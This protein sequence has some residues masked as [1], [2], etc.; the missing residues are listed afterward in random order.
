MRMEQ[1]H[2]TRARRLAALALRTLGACVVITALAGPAQAEMM[3]YEFTGVVDWVGAIGSGWVLD[4]SVT[5]GT[6]FSGRFTFDSDAPDLDPATDESRYSNPG[7]SL[8]VDVG[9]YSWSSGDGAT[10]GSVVVGG[11]WFGAVGFP[12]GSSLWA[13]HFICGLTVPE[14]SG[15]ALPVEPFPLLNSSFSAKIQDVPFSGESQF[16]GHLTQ[17]NIVPE[18][19]AVLLIAVGL[20]LLQHRPAFRRVG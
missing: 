8:S 16:G 13:N 12:A 10:E 19:A 14:L 11:F 6:P 20:A 17:F 1:L 9:S 3:A 7:F 18:P 2:M 15:G 4:N 5:V